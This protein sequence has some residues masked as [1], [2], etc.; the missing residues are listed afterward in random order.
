MEGIP[1]FVSRSVFEFTPFPFSLTGLSV[2][3]VHS[4]IEFYTIVNV[5]NRIH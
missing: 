5:K 2:F 3:N 4:V 1:F